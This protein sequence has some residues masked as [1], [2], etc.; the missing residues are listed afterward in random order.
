M[1]IMFFSGTGFFK[2]LTGFFVLVLAFG[3]QKSIYD[4][5]SNLNPGSLDGT[6]AGVKNNFMV[7]ANSETLPVDFE[8]KIS[9]YGQIVKTI[10]EIGVVVVKPGVSNFEQK[11]A[12]LTEV[13]AVVPDLMTKWIEPERFSKVSKPLSIGDNEGFFGYLWGMD[14]INAPEAWDAGYTGSGAKVFILDSGIDAEHPD[15]APNLIPALSTSFV[16]DEDWNVQPGE[17]FN[18]GSHVAGIIAGADN[19][20]GIIGVAPHTGIVAVKVLSEYDETGAFSWIIEGIVYAANNGADV[21]NMSI[22]AVLNRNGFY[23]DENSTLQKIPAVYIQRIIHA[24]QRAVT[25]AFKNGVTIVV[26]AGNEDMNADGNGSLIVLPADL[27]NVIAVSATAPDY[28]YQSWA[29]ATA[30]DYDIPSSYTNYG[31][32][33]VKVAAPGGDFDFEPLY[34]FQFDM[35]LSTGSESYWFAAG[36][37]MAAP[38]VSGVAALVIS[39]NSDLTPG[40]VTKQLFKTADDVDGEGVTPYFGFGR[41]NAFRAVTE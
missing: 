35:V 18:H 36:T 2:I 1:K 19:S 27:Q 7:I 38:H 25:Y 40:E 39:K 16:P 41:I 30:P 34:G 10:P 5:D 13:N 37:S 33:L 28:I 3:C 9:A 15:L 31:R 22:G 4:S 20:M 29:N 14:A 32:S 17:F 21:I 26:A 23:Y 11:V 12:K 6:R 24:M 8:K